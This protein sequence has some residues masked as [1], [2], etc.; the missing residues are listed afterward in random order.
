MPKSYPYITKAVTYPKGFRAAGARGGLK[1]EGPDCALIV[2]DAPCPAAAV[3]TTNLFQAA[4]VVVSKR[5][6]AGGAIKAIAVNSGC[7]N[8]VTGQRGLEDAVEMARIAAGLVECEPREVLVASTG[9]IGHNLPM[10]KIADGLTAAAKRLSDVHDNGAALAIM[11]TDLSPKTVAV[12]AEVGG[13]AIRIGGICKGSGMIA[14]NMA[15]MLAFLTTDAAVEPAALQS[16]LSIA[17]SRTF[18]RVTVDGDNSTNDT[19]ALL[20]SGATGNTPVRDGTPEHAAFTL[21]LT[22][23]CD[24]LARQIAAD[25]EGAT[26]LVVVNVGGAPSEEDAARIARTIAESPL[27]K[28]ALFGNDPNWGRILAAAGR[29]GVP[30]DAT[31]VGLHIGAMELV[32]EGEP[33]AVDESAAREIISRDEVDIR[34]DLHNGDA[35]ATIYTCDF[36][37]DY[38][39]INAEYHT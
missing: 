35:A 32:K 31:K 18:N 38:V 19:V 13:V 37:Y 3:F 6:L 20:A 2:A 25:G 10:G 4:P 36:S 9:V 24:L 8:A 15:T 1:S 17:V 28:T 30:F 5:H 29:A 21:A 16:A 27:T 26:K 33:V 7:A 12:D 14:P 39:R 11:T 34:L 22:S 23:A